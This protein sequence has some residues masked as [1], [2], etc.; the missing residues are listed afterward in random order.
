M[1]SHFYLILKLLAQVGHA[2]TE[3]LTSRRVTAEGRIR[4]KASPCGICGG[5]SGRGTGFSTRIS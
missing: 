3:A 1:T 4:S 2:M 5:Q